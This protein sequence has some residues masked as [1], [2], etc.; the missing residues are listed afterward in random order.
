MERLYPSDGAA[1]RRKLKSD[2]DEDQPIQNK[3]QRLPDGPDLDANRGREEVDAAAGQEQS[4]SDDRQHARGVNL[5]RRQIGGIGHQDA[6]GDLDRAIVDSP[7]DV[8]DDPAD[9]QAQ[10]NAAADEPGEGQDAAR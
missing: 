7:L 4:A 5:L 1:N 8:V 3:I 6:E 2:E 10:A 9:E